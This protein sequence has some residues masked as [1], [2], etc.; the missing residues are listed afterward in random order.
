MEALIAMMVPKIATQNPVGCIAPSCT[1]PRAPMPLD[2]FLIFT[3]LTSRAPLK[4]LR[5]L[6]ERCKIPSEVR[7]GRP[8]RK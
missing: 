7:G 6:E 5:G 1:C 2:P 3:P 4:Q 8:G